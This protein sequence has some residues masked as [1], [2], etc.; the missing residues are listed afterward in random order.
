MVTVVV[1]NKSSTPNDVTLL[2]FSGPVYTANE[3]TRQCALLLWHSA[4]PMH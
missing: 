4:L 2:I 3:N 1:K